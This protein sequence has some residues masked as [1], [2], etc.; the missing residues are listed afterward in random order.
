MGHPTYI[1][2]AGKQ[3]QMSPDD[4]KAPCLSQALLKGAVNQYPGLLTPKQKELTDANKVLTLQVQADFDK[5]LGDLLTLLQERL[6]AG[7][8]EAWL[9]DEAYGPSIDRKTIDD[10]LAA[11][12]PSEEQK[13]EPDYYA[14]TYASLFDIMEFSADPEEAWARA[15]AEMVVFSMYGNPGHIHFWKDDA[16]GLFPEYPPVFPILMACQYLSTYAILSRGFK[17]ESVGGGLACSGGTINLP[18][19]DKTPQ[20]AKELG[21]VKEGDPDADDSKKNPPRPR[22]E[23]GPALPK[24]KTKQETAPYF[25]KTDV[26]A[27][28]QAGPGSVVT[29]NPGGPGEGSQNKGAITHVATVLRRH[30]S[31]VQFIDTGVLVGNDESKG[32]GSM[33]GGE[34]GTT[35]HGFVKGTL[36]ASTSCVAVGVL[37]PPP[38]DLK[39]ATKAAAAARPLGFAR[40]A[41]VDVN[42][43]AKPIVRFVSRM[44]HMQY[45]VSRYIWSLRGLPVKGLRLLWMIYTPQGDE[46]TKATI[47]GLKDTPGAVWKTARPQWEARRA[48]AGGTEGWEVKH[49]MSFFPTNIVRG[50]DTGK[51]VVARRKVDKADG[52]VEDF[53]APTDAQ[54]AKKPKPEM[55]QGYKLDVPFTLG[56]FCTSKDNLDAQYVCKPG[57]GEKGAIDTTGGADFLKPK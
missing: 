43:A 14:K 24:D 57:A 18:C 32:S 28:K 2:E 47:K 13:K 35:D 8:G 50:E 34:G 23:L 37:L 9:A 12:P 7:C 30:G 3:A 10:K 54:M 31:Q 49:Q 25:A 26:L 11:N 16:S 51:A 38:G 46:F 27:K 4:Y 53:E 45:P 5:E 17:P 1:R 20:P 56:S 21:L 55:G 52:W 6:A 36:P 29:F 39:E 41:I 44:V 15:F 19:F 42:D 22:S 33:A 48:G 40:L